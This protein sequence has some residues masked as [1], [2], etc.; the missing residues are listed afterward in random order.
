IHGDLADNG[1]TVTSSINK[2]QFSDGTVVNLGQ[3]TPITFTWLDN[4]N[5]FSQGGS[6]FGSNVF[7]V[8]A[9]NGTIGF[10]NTSNGGDGKNTVEYAKGD[11]AL[12]LWPGSSTGTLQ[13]GAGI[14][15]SDVLL[16]ANSNDLV[17]QFRGDTTDSILIH[18]DLADNGG[19]V[20][21]SINKLQFSDGTVVNLGQGTPITFTWLDNSNGFSQ[22]GSSFG[23]NVFEVT[24][25]N[26]TIGFGNTSNGGDGKNTVEYAK[27]DGALT[28]WPGSSTGT[29]QFGAGIT[30]SDVLLQANSN[31]LFVQFRGDTTDSI[32][33]HGDLTDNGGTVTSSI[34]KL[35]FSDGT[36]VNLGQGTPITFTWLGTP[37]S[38]LGGAAYGANVFEFGQGSES[39][40]GGSTNNGGNGNN[41]YLASTNTGRATIYANAASG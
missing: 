29:L 39:A 18:G 30:A 2:L 11:G 41:T 17:V 16:Q 27:G 26:G 37:N 25:T 4:S 3:G 12:A 15:A 24:A 21:S 35:Q 5:G 1:G 31:D 28:I 38:S 22:G 10:G 23:S 19:T 6:S 13:F 8:T 33:I 9:T 7:E 32:W 34:N 14:T 40:S 20:T 36:V